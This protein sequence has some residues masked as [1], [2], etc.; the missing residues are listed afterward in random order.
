MARHFFLFLLF[1]P[2]MAGGV[3][4]QRKATVERSLRE[5]WMKYENGTYT[6]LDKTSDVKN[7][8]YFK[9]ETSQFPGSRLSVA[10]ARPF[11]V[12]FNGKLAGEYEGHRQFNLDSLATA[13]Y[14]SSLFVT[15]HQQHINLRDLK[16]TVITRQ[17]D[18]APQPD[19]TKPA[20]Y[21]KDFVI[22]AGLLIIMLFLVTMKFNPKLGAD[23][24]SVIRIFSTRE[25]DDAQAN[26][27]LTN[28]S[29]VQFYVV[30]SL[31][32]GFYLMIIVYHLP[33]EYALPL[34]FQGHGFWSVLWQWIRLSAIVLS[35]FFIRI[36]LIFSLTRL[37]GLKGLARVHFFNWVR[38]LLIIFGAATIILFAYY[39]LRGHSAGLFIAFLSLVVA[40]LIAWVFIIFLKLNNKSEHSMFHLFSYICATEIIPLLITIKVLFQ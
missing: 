17:G 8:L 13:H 35:V 40:T 2:W 31:L 14:T 38:L 27:R 5:H 20:T 16:T 19:I 18:A 7:T 39:I 26:A 34:Y 21:F 37:F 32:L 23:Y 24:F 15:I 29:N 22:I 6:L 3:Y 33:D 25:G 30:C 11:F 9:L 1:L 36:L 12:F 10:S 4:A 28:G